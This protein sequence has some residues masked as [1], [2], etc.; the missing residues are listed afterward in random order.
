M[1]C[2]LQYIHVMEEFSLKMMLRKYTT[3]M[4]PPQRIVPHMSFV[5]CVIDVNILIRH[6]KLERIFLNNT[7]TD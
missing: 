6:H 7:E 2:C 3:L 4:S 1:S 5:N